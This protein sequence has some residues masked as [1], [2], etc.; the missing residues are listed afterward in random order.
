MLL[1][2]PVLLR[3]TLSGGS[4]EFEDIK[5]VN[6]NPLVE[7]GQPNFDRQNTKQKTKD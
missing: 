1:Q 5:G 7:E 4:E 3:R 6:Q 2:S